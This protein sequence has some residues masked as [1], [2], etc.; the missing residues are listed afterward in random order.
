MAEIK[1]TLLDNAN[2]F[3][4]EALAKAVAA[5]KDPKQWKYAILN[6]VQAIELSLKELLR[7]QHEI[8]IYSNVDSPNKTVT[9]EQARDRLIKIAQIKFDPDD[10]S[11]I[12]TASDYRNQIVHY[13]FSFTDSDLK[14]VFAKLLGF[15]QHFYSTHLETPLDSV[16]GGS[17]WQEAVSISEYASELFK[18][19]NTRIQNEGIDEQ[20]VW[21]CRA[22]GWKA[23]V[24]QDEI[25]NCFVCGNHEDVGA[26]ERCGDFSYSDELHD[27]GKKQY[28]ESCRDYLTDD[29]WYEQL[30]GK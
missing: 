3:A 5:E 1:L 4:C 14:L 9:L 21:I 10:L 25:N 12:R 22:C 17:L 6:L 16:V 27:L 30:A 13:Q 11:S 24:I 15:L 29:Y 8:L 26:C 19:A 20:L 18:R 7:D 28:C 23:F 2:S